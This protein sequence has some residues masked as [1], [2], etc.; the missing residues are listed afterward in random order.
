L[1]VEDAATTGVQG[2]G[3]LAEILEEIRAHSI[4]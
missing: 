4:H 2:E 3:A 1:D